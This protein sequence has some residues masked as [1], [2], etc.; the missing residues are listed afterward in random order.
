[1]IYAPTISRFSRKHVAISRC[2]ARIFPQFFPQLPADPP[3]KHIPAA[4]PAAAGIW[5]IAAASKHAAAFEM[6]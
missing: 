3:K 5:V 6:K 4:I 1:M 2:P